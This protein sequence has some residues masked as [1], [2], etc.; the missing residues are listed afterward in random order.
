[1]Y[2]RAYSA[3]IAILCIAPLIAATSATAS[4]DKLC[5]SNPRVTQCLSVAGSAPTILAQAQQQ[6]KGAP[7]TAVPCNECPTYDS[8]CRRALGPKSPECDAANA[9]CLST[10]TK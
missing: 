2:R 9:H 3:L 5:S 10:C 4:A 8:N 1:M 7:Q 6:W